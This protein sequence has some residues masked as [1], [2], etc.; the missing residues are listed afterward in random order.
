MTGFIANIGQS[1]VVLSGSKCFLLLFKLYCTYRFA[2][3]S[4]IERGVLHED[5][6]CIACP[7]GT[8]QPSSVANDI[9]DC[10]NC[11]LGKWHNLT[12]QIQSSI[13]KGCLEGKV[14]FYA[15]YV[16]ESAILLF[17][18]ITQVESVNICI[19]KPRAALVRLMVPTSKLSKA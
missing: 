16:G 17:P 6:I 7:A 5:E 18:Y 8:F 15:H 9:S 12:G 10:L 4:L 2:I 14:S 19:K 11:P 13:C 3:R 1:I